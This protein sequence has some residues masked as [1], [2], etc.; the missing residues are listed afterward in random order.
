MPKMRNATVLVIDDDPALRLGLGETLRL[1]GYRVDEADSLAAGREWLRRP[2]PAAVLLDLQL[3]DGLGL[4]LL[5]HLKDGW[6]DVP[7]IMM[8]AHG[9]IDTAVKAM[10]HGAYSYL[11]KPFH[12]EELKLVLSQ[13][14]E[15]SRLRWQAEDRQRR[16][17]EEF[18]FE[19]IVARSTAMKRVLDQAGKVA[20][21]P[22]STVLL[23]GE[24]GTGKGLVARAIHYASD[25]ASAPFLTVTC[26]AIPEPLL[27]AELLGHEKGAFTDAKARRRGVFEAADGGTVFLDEIGDMP[28]ALQAKLLGVLEDRS[29]SRIGSTET[30][31]V[32]VR[33]IAATHRDLD[34]HVADGRFRE[35]LLYRLRVVPIVIPPLR[36]RTS[37]IIPLA[38]SYVHHFNRE[39]GRG[40]EGFAPTAEEML[41]GHPWPGNVR[42]LRNVIERALLFTRHTQLEAEDLM[43]DPGYRP[44]APSSATAPQGAGGEA[45]TLPAD[46]VKLDELENDLVRQA[47]ERAQ[48][49]KSRAAKILGISRDQIRYRLEKMGES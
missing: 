28:L 12:T 9:S 20:E 39:F 24:S 29:F 17:A 47:M 36:E 8:T 19:K 49:N 21:S 5:P 33:I 40:V 45:F 46:G 3:T 26:S 43:L 6:P 2:P 13:A 15:N 37:D 18:S 22:A 32:D 44:R 11:Q 48:G 42:E 34:R 16:R 10:Q 31:Q 25:R 35:D 23:L 41:K 1:F 7:V 27:E 4:E 30:I 38:E 14:I